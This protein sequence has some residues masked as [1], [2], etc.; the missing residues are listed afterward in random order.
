MGRISY[1]IYIIHIPFIFSVSC[2]IFGQLVGRGVGY[3]DSV[4]ITFILSI[5]IVL[6]VAYFYHRY[7]ETACTKV[8][9]ILMRLVFPVKE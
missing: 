6:M 1:S 4:M 7:V 2:Y 9:N 3:L 5:A 8:L